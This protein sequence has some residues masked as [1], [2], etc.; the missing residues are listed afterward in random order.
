MVEPRPPR[1][2]QADLE[3]TAPTMPSIRPFH[4]ADLDALYDI[5]LRTGDS[6]QDASALHDDPKLIGHLY[7]APYALLEPA[8]AFV[9]EDE[10]GV[11][12]YIVGA[13]DTRAFDARLETEWWPALRA[14]YDDPAAKPH[15]SWSADERRQYL[16]HHPYKTPER[17]VAVYPAHLHINLLPRLQGRDI[18]RRLLDRFLDAVGEAGARGVHLGCGA[19]NTRALHFYARYG[20]SEIER[21]ARTQT[22]WVGIEVSAAGG[23]TT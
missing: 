21:S 2:R 4:P 14:Q 5:A 16:I 19:T 6:G 22:V 13:A 9:A 12:G 18:G 10:A 7:A 8:R 15:E 23:S 11:A 1:H 20:F 3:V 17:I